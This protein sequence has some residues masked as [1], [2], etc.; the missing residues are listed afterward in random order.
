MSATID[1]LSLTVF[2]QTTWKAVIICHE[3][4]SLSEIMYVLEK[5]SKDEDKRKQ[6]VA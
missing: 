5:V 2:V 4:Y 3:S 6:H 1:R